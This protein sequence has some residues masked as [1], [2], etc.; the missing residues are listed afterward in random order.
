MAKTIVKMATRPE[1]RRKA[2]RST[3]HDSPCPAASAVVDGDWN[4]TS[5]EEW[6]GGCEDKAFLFAM[7]FLRDEPAVQEILREAFVSVARN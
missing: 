2:E 4:F 1:R 7:H 5:L 3:G 6:V